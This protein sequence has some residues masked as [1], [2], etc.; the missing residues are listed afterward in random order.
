MG[1]TEYKTGPHKFHLLRGANYFV[2][3]SIFGKDPSDFGH[4]LGA[5]CE[6][7][8]IHVNIRWSGEF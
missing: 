8:G 5:D 3:Y 1:H 7:R 2:N 6:Q 4:I